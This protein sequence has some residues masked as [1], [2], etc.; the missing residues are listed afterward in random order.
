MKEKIEEVTAEDLVALIYE[1]A[2]RPEFKKVH[3]KDGYERWRW[4]GNGVVVNLLRTNGEMAFS[5]W[6]MN[7]LG[8]PNMYKA[9]IDAAK[10]F[11]DLL[12]GRLT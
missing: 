4:S 10:S 11:A 12:T 1:K 8:G 5:A 3:G 9:T 7:P 2:G 6:G